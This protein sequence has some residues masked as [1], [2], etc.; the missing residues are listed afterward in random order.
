ML[1]AALAYWPSGGEF[2][3][4]STQYAVASPSPSFTLNMCVFHAPSVYSMLPTF[5]RVTL[6]PEASARCAI[7]AP[8][9]GMI[10]AH[11]SSR[12]HVMARTLFNAPARSPV[13][14]ESFC[15]PSPS[16]ARPADRCRRLWE[17]PCYVH[18]VRANHPGN[19]DECRP[20][21]GRD[22][23]V[24]RH[25]PLSARTCAARVLPSTALRVRAFGFSG[26]AALYSAQH[27]AFRTI[28]KERPWV[29]YQS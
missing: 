24:I 29:L 20:F 16:S 21:S 3:A 6:D 7:G 14:H 2:L 19:L 9:Q 12:V 4:G 11:T 23:H 25:L 26:G 13:C 18:S 27:N 1:N 15:M 28:C 22:P 5:Q 8:A 10:M 17:S